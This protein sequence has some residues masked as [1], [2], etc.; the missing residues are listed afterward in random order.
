M[1]PPLSRHPGEGR[2]PVKPL[3]GRAQSTCLGPRLRGG[4]D[5]GGG[6]SGAK[7]E[8]Y[9]EPT[10][11]KP[12]VFALPPPRFEPI[13][14]PARTACLWDGAAFWDVDVAAGGVVVASG[15]VSE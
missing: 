10:T 5:L 13:D 4:D 12:G 2:D 14:G 3:Q 1:V 15:K 8:G 6:E 9:A 11:S 7:A